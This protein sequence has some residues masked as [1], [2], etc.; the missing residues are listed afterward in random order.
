MKKYVLLMT[1]ALLL[2]FLSACGGD[3][4]VEPTSFEAGKLT[5]SFDYEKIS[6][7]A[8]NQ[9]AV[10]IEDLD[11]NF[12]N[13]VYATRWTAKGGYK[14]RPDSIATWADKSDLASMQKSDVDVIAGATPKASGLSYSW[15]L[16][17]TKGNTVPPGEYKFFVEGTLR[18]KNHV[19][20]SGVITLGD[21]PMIV[22]AEADFVYEKSDRYDAITSDSAENKMITAVTATFTPNE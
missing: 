14:S 19:I 8:S 10:W 11:G 1:T 5:I 22:Q 9:F 7:S 13:T 2:V 20:Y 18:W 4:Y 6:G 16:R 15:N 17:D 21:E 12:I 3:T